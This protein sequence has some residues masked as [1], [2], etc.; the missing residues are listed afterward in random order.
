MN[1]D[2]KTLKQ[3]KKMKAQKLRDDL[4]QQMENNTA[5]K[6]QDQ[7]LELEQDREK[8]N[9]RT[10]IEQSLIEMEKYNKKAE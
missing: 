6:L 4:I 10:L 7:S 3:L 2:P 5:M 9:E 8:M 1:N